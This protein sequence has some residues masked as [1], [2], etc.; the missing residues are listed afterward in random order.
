M[1]FVEGVSVGCFG[2]VDS[3]AV[4]AFSIKGEVNEFRIPFDGGR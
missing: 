3:E 4:I 1:W 2:L